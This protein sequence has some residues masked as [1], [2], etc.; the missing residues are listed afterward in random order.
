MQIK[1]LTTTDPNNKVVKTYTEDQTI[2]A[3]IIDGCSILKP[4]FTLELNSMPTSNYAYIAD[5]NRYYF[6]DNPIAEC[7]GVYT[8]KMSVDVLMSFANGIK[9]LTGVISRQEN[10]N[11]YNLYLEDDAF[12][13]YAYPQ[14]VTKEFPSGFGNVVHI[15]SF[16][17]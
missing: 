2:E 4:E 11:A 9:A 10:S 6:I 17:K 1:L 14:V 15:Y 7:P 5:F 16:Q 8:L 3:T 13:A 12:K